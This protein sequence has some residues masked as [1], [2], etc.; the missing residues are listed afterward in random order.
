MD[1]SKNLTEIIKK[2]IDLRGKSIPKLAEMIG[3]NTST[4]YDKL[5]NNRISVEDLFKISVA[6]DINLEWLKAA[7]GYSYQSSSFKPIEVLRMSED[8]RYAEIPEVKKSIIRCYLQ[9][10]DDLTSTKKELL[11]TYKNL[12]YILDVMLPE[13]FKIFTITERKN[14]SF[15]VLSPDQFHR[16][17]MQTSLEKGTDLLNEIILNVVR[18]K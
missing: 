16:K 18:S 14:S 8:Y 15:W 13:D 7:L 9:F 6:L 12:F 10:P 1:N 3:V 17:G 5:H 11:S 2:H 4:L